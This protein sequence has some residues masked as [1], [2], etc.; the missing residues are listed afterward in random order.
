M[1]YLENAGIGNGFFVNSG[2]GEKGE[3]LHERY[4]SAKPFPHIAITDFLPPT[5]LENC[6]TNFPTTVGSESQSF[7]RDQ[8]RFKTSYNPEHLVDTTRSLFYSFNSGPF[9]AFLEGLTG[10]E[11]LIPDPYFIGGGF[12]EIKQGGYLSIH[13]DFNHH[14]TLNLERRVNVLIYLNKDWREEYGG[15]LELWDNDMKSCEV[16]IL[17]AFNQAVIFN[18]STTSNHGNPKPIA[19]PEGISRRSIALYYYTATWD[20]TKRDHTTQFRGRLGTSDRTDWQVRFKEGLSEILPPL[21]FRQLLR[22]MY[23]LGW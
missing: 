5:L 4:K 6:L 14:K 20:G 2:M 16:S 3:A 22:V 8:E 12:H 7:D 15:Q 23:R 13:A 10:I 9:L 19:H 21:V 1:P 11:G 18:T 17:P